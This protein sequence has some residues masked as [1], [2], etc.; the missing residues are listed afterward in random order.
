MVFALAFI[1]SPLASAMDD[2]RWLVPRSILESSDIKIVWQFNLPLSGS[3]TLEQFFVAEV[4]ILMTDRKVVAAVDDM[5]TAELLRRE[6]IG[7]LNQG[8]VRKTGRLGEVEP[9]V[10]LGGELVFERHDHDDRAHALQR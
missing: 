10:S 6:E 5:V 4:E 8:K 3:E 7:V 9:V 2:S 1:F